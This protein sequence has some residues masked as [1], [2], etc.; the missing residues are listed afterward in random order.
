MFSAFLFI[1]LS[2]NN[3]LFSLL[4]NNFISRHILKQLLIYFETKEN[5][6]C[7]VCVSTIYMQRL[8]HNIN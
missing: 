5:I 6:A 3:P 2:S 7:Y 8:S 1:Y 4:L